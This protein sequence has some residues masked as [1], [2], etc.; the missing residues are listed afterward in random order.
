MPNQQE[1]VRPQPPVQPEQPVNELDRKA[2]Q[3]TEQVREHL[4][5]LKE[6]RP[7]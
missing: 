4:A 6:D 2:D 7:K 3:L 1:E 5:R